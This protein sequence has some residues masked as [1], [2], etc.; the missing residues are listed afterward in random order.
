MSDQEF[1]WAEQAGNASEVY[2]EFLVPGMFTPFAEKL[3]EEAGVGPGARVLDVACGTGIVS[4]L[5][6]RRAGAEGAVTGVDMTEPMLAVARTQANDDGAA[7]ITY[8]QGDAAALPVA[9][10]SFDFVTC[11]HGLQF[12][13]DKVGA[14][15][16]ARRALVDGGVLAV[17]CW[18]GGAPHMQALIDALTRRLGEELGSAMSAPFVLG[19]QDLMRSIVE[20]AGFGDVD[21]HQV[22]ME[23]TFSDHAN[24]APRMLA[25]G[26]LAGPFGEAPEGLR[27]A[28]TD[29]VARALEP[30]ATPTGGIAAPM[31]STVAIAR[32]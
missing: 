32:A 22:T 7:P 24:F 27:A 3:L 14:L 26:P 8:A 17:G 6:A 23:V 4:R 18:E 20:E 30:Y 11:H 2:Q 25:A 12:F 1:E 16:D 31:T 9:D 10:G 28:V 15:R 19:D 21:V 13:P 29:D 5:A